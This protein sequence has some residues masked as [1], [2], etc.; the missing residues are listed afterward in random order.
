MPQE[1]PV[2]DVK[3][4]KPAVD[5]FLQKSQLRFHS[6]ALF[7]GQF[8]DFQLPTWTWRHN[9]VLSKCDQTFR[10][11][12]EVVTHFSRLPST[13]RSCTSRSLSSN[14]L[15]HSIADWI[16]CHQ[17]ASQSVSTQEYT[18]TYMSVSSQSA[19]SGPTTATTILFAIGK[20]LLQEKGKQREHLSACH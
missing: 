7:I 3:K 14:V 2:R 13:S 9:V 16:L 17:P 18:Y 4:P 12:V 10:T 20:A 5:F 11:R 8:L 6:P 15:K 19:I 1:Q